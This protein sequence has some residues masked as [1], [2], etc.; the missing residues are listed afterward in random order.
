M[1]KWLR[2]LG[3]HSRAGSSVGFAG[4]GRRKASVSGHGLSAGSAFNPSTGP[5]LLKRDQ[6]P[7]KY[8]IKGEKWAAKRLRKAQKNNAQKAPKA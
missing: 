8:R 1:T 5:G 3:G 7:E 4:W 2:Y 6:V